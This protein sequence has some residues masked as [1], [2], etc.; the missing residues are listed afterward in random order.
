MLGFAKPSPGPGVLIAN[1][2]PLDAA[3]VAGRLGPRVSTARFNL[4]KR[5]AAGLARPRA[6]PKDRG[7]GHACSTPRSDRSATKK[8]R[9]AHPRSFC[10]AR[11]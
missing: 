11:A 1:W 6:G 10:S 9:A 5:T 7:A 4:D 8:L 2:E 3:D